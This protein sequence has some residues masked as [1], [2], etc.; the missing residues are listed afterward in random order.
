MY[1]WQ[2]LVVVQIRVVLGDFWALLVAGSRGIAN[3][4]HQ[5]D[6]C[7]TYGLLTG[8]M[9]VDPS[10]VV[11]MMYDDVAWSDANPLVGRLFN[12]PNGV[13]VYEDCNIDFGRSKVTVA[14]FQ[15]I[16]AGQSSVSV[17]SNAEST[18]FLSFV[19]HGE[20]GSL[21]LP[22]GEALSGES[23]LQAIN[24]MN[25]RF[26]RLVIYVEACFAGSVFERIQLPANVIAITASNST[27]SSWGTFCPTPQHPG[28][29]E[30][31]GVH[32]GACLGDLFEVSWKRDL[33]TRDDWATA[34]FGDHVEAV[35]SIVARKSHVMVYGDRS[36]LSQPLAN[37]FPP[38]VSGSKKNGAFSDTLLIE[39]AVQQRAMAANPETARH[40]TIIAA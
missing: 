9:H 24:A 19:D 3:Y 32:I 30:V 35:K 37:I 15:K 33:E 8:S 10:H 7:H 23:I 18:V 1:A 29:D 39:S 14:N 38:I 12:E 20:P 25:N 34:T 26:K 31:N 40:D 21:L 36:L 13:N 4:R 22:S 6:L 17:Q 28:A 27:E 11:T 5:A 16:L 2:V